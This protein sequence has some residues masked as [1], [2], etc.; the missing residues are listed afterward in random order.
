LNDLVAMAMS[1]HRSGNL[2]EARHLYQLILEKDQNNL[3]ALHLLGI[4]EAQEQNADTA[5]RL[6]DTAIEINPHSADVLADKGK[7][8]SEIRRYTDALICYQKAVAINPRHLQALHNQ[9]C[10]L[11][12]LGR[13]AEALTIFDRLLDI[14]PR[15]LSA[16]HNRAIALTDLCRYAEAVA[17]CDSALAINPDYP[18]ALQ[19]RGTALEYL[20]R[21][22]LALA[23]F[24]HALS[25]N[26]R[27][28]YLLGSLISSQLYC[29]DFQHLD[30][31]INQLTTRVRR[32]ERAVTPFAF[33]SMSDN[34]SDQLACSRTY[35]ADKCPN[36]TPKLWQNE[37]YHHEKIRLAYLSADFRQHPISYLCAG[38]FEHHD[39]SR[40]ETFAVSYGPDDNSDILDRIKHS[41]DSFIE[42]RPMND[43][44]VA[45]L[46]RRHEIDIL[47][48][49][50]GFTQFN[51]MG[52]L[53]YKPA[54]IQVGY[55]GFPGTTGA[56]FIDYIIADRFVIPEV[57]QHCYSEKAVYLP[58]TFQA[59]DSKR[60]I[61]NHI[62]SRDD[63]GLPEG[64]FVFCAFGN[65]HKITPTFFDIWMRLL[66]KIDHSV[67]WLL[68]GNADVNHNLQKEAE[69]RG[70]SSARLIFA[71]KIGYSDYLARYLLADLF[72]DTL[73]FNAGATASDALCAGLPLITCSGETFA[74][75]MAGSLLKAIGMPEMITN[76]LADYEALASK[77]AGD[78]DLI[79]SIKMKLARNRLS[80]P[81]FN[82]QL[83]TR[84]IEMAYAAMYKRHHAGLPPDHIYVPQSR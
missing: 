76:S 64:A 74:A 49:L 42:A 81:L 72:L 78:R 19:S 68:D 47:V 67:L 37:I 10:T 56:D 4:L 77:L 75:R 1:A 16:L 43:V 5:L 71:P 20:H 82:T 21:H 33:L 65:P 48:D 52:V 59:N 79:A 18:E 70:I 63:V 2:T 50:T 23:N 66:Q 83:F 61:A 35:V 30:E 29:H 34:A 41:V 26:P 55:L 40:F 73:P 60:H 8:L 45:T 31:H 13:A 22:D 27:L 24:K 46:L 54:P 53:A 17:S 3:P 36:V 51:R 32:N 6:F 84:N 12:F 38:L 25:L 58:N 69:R 62:P 11:L 9:G 15:F 44:E 57:Q 14:E 80:H 28:E 39:S 7:V